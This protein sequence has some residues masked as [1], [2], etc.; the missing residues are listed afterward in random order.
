MS[1]DDAL[2]PEV[3]PAD[4]VASARLDGDTSL[5]AGEL[6]PIDLAARQAELRSIS[7]M[8]GEAVAIPPAATVDAHIAA[9]I[10]SLSSSSA[11]EA[12]PD[13]SPQ[14]VVPITGRA[15]PNH[16]RWL[17]VAT[18][19][20]AVALVGALVAATQTHSVS[21]DTVAGPV[22]ADISSSVNPQSNPGPSEQSTG[23]ART[24]SQSDTATSDTLPDL[25][26]VTTDASLD[27]EVRAQPAM[28]ANPEPTTTTVTSFDQASSTTTVASTVAPLVTPLKVTPACDEAV[29]AAVPGL[30]HLVF[31]ATAMYQNVPVEV[32]VYAESQLGSYRLIA[33]QTAGCVIVANHLL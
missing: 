23:E 8:V 7:A 22:A 20:V 32:L 6:D 30:G 18:A 21:T 28:Q 17:A 13:G 11:G 9:A 2:T 14:P 26:V 19:I 3:D 12:D 4:L 16:R 24:G 10:A 31:A 33:A 5:P 29:R 25:G 15:R 27:A 1:S